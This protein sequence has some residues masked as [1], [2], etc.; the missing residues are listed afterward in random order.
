M[1]KIVN[2]QFDET[3][4]THT[5]DNGLNLIFILLSRGSIIETLRFINSVR[6]MG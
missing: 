4:Y 5:L 6:Y 3:W 1:K 2:A